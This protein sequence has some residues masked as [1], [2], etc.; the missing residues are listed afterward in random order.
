M[1]V[2]H[3]QAGA[4]P[5]LAGD[6]DVLDLLYQL[7]NEGPAGQQLVPEQMRADSNAGQVLVDKGREGR[8]LLVLH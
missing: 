5:D 7:P 3:P 4:R 6:L 8:D 1:H 2:G